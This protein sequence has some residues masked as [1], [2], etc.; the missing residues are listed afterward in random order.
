MEDE[1]R[2]Q[3][4]ATSAGVWDGSSAGN[5]ES[6]VQVAV[7]TLL[8]G[9]LYDQAEKARTSPL[10]V[11]DRLATNLPDFSIFSGI[12][13]FIFRASAIAGVGIIVEHGGK[14]TYQGVRRVQGQA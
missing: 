14:N 8:P 13:H 1:A 3:I 9:S 7:H 10:P 6:S 2:H 4:A 11:Y 5:P 12:P